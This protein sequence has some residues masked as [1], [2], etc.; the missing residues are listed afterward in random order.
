[1]K[2]LLA[3]LLAILMVAC[4]GMTAFAANPGQNEAVV[5]GSDEFESNEAETNVDILVSAE[6]IQAVVP[7]NLAIVAKVGGGDCYVPTNYGIINKSYAPIKVTNVK[8]VVNDT[9]WRLHSIQIAEGKAPT[10][11]A[12]SDLFL[13]IGGATV[14]DAKALNLSTATGATGTAAPAGWTM[15]AASD[16]DGVKLDLPVIANTSMIRATVADKYED[17]VTITYTIA[18][19]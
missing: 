15:A 14:E 18:L 16:A 19:Q 13:V 11:A 7:L 1:M 2:K 4:V 8:A 5:S 9:N 3:V 6:N 12:K 17:A 10:E